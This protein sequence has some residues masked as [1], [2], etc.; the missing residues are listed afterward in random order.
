MAVTDIDPARRW[1]IDGLGAADIGN[2]RV[3][4]GNTVVLL[5]EEPNRPRTGPQRARGF[6]YLT[7]QIRDVRAEHARLLELGTAEGIAPIQLGEVA[8]I[9]FVRSPDGDWLELSQ[10][11]SLTGPLPGRS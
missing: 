9:S 8:F 6:R 3:Q 11:A 1:W 4:L 5:L 10:R 7:V 2:S